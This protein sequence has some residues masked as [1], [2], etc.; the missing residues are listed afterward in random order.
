MDR[1]VHEITGG[2]E[3][4]PRGKGSASCCRVAGGRA[5]RPCRRA[6]PFTGSQGVGR[7][8]AAGGVSGSWPSCFG[9]SASFTFLFASAR[10]TACDLALGEI[11]RFTA[12]LSADGAV[13][14]LVPAAVV[15]SI[16]TARF[17]SSL[18]SGRASC[19]GLG[20]TFGGVVDVVVS[21]A[22]SRFC[23]S[24]AALP[25]P[26]RNVTVAGGVRPDGRLTDSRTGFVVAGCGVGVA[27]TAGLPAGRTWGRC[28]TACGGLT[29][30][31]SLGAT[32]GGVV[33]TFL[34]VSF[35]GFFSSRAGLSSSG[36]A[37]AGRA[38]E[39][40]GCGG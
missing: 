30:K 25:A 37:G 20:A 3:G 40:R 18:V 4:K 10:S 5:T 34:P 23:T 35:S 38:G 26:G 12:G 6:L 24:R 16:L 8:E 15:A 9:P 17:V 33:V 29:S 31:V 7:V 19:L 28:G 27:A 21:I 11:G 39:T 2:R 36:R 22:A 13:C 32:F 14:R 1:S